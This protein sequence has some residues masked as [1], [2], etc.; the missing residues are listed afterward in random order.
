M[1]AA[2]MRDQI[3]ATLPATAE[4]VH[5][6]QILFYNAEEAQNVYALLQSGWDF[7][8]LAEQYDPLTKGELGWF[9]RG[10][11]EH[12]TIEEA[13]FALQPGQYSPVV[14]SSI[15]FHILYLVERDPQH[16]LSPDALLALQERALQDWLSLRRNESTIV[17]AP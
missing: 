3:I 2:W 10:Y 6:K 15:G 5:V 4:Q 9:P 12:P 1:A 8:V 16:L 7:N 17:V 11:L 13:A 14:E